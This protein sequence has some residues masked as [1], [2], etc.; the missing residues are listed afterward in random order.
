[1]VLISITGTLFTD[2][3]SDNL[4]VSLVSSNLVF[5]ISLALTF[6]AWYSS[7]KT[8]AIHTIHTNRRESFYW[9]TILFTFAL[10]T[11]T[12]DLVAESFIF[13]YAISFFIFAVMV[14]YLVRS[15]RD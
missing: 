11:A 6:I 13:G 14:T 9:I 15:K 8:V 2:N 5:S 1:M 3:L 10:G 4:H 7:E 12:G